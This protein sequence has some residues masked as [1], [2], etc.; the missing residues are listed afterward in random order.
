MSVLAAAIGISVISYMVGHHMCCYDDKHDFLFLKLMN[1]VINRD[2]EAVTTFVIGGHEFDGH[3]TLELFI[4]GEKHMELS[5]KSD[6]YFGRAGDIT[7][8]MTD[9]EM[10]RI[11]LHDATG[12]QEKVEW[13]HNMTRYYFVHM[14]YN[15]L[16]V[17]EFDS[18]PAMD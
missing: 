8:N 2:G 17:R 7:V 16:R 4:D 10:I 9:G 5:P 1:Y 6:D 15:K 18:Y 13:Q 12:K 14:W 11:I 3:K